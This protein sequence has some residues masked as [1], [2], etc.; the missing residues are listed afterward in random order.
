[1]SN[2]EK[3]VKSKN[4]DQV[5][6]TE[7]SKPENKLF[8]WNPEDKIVITG[9]EFAIINQYSKYLSGVSD[10]ILSRLINEGKVSEVTE[11]DIAESNV[12][13]SMKEEKKDI[14]V[15]PISNDEIASEKPSKN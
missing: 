5:Q 9:Q 6:D 15:D 1:M 11:K 4:T 13:Q 10:A 7:E 14:K 8:K 3:E 2:E 12:R